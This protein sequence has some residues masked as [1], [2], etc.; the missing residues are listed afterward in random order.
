MAEMA[1]RRGPSPTGLWDECRLKTGGGGTPG[2]ARGA[3]GGTD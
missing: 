1:R 2:R 3:D